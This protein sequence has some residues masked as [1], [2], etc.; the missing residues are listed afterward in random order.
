MGRDARIALDWADGHYEF[1]LAWGQLIELQEQCDAGPFVV[2]NRLTS[3]QWRMQDIGHT[4][5]LGL[6]GGGLE[7]AKALKL[8]RDYVESRPPLENLML[9]RGILAAALMGA[10]DEP[11]GEAQGEAASGSTTS[12]TASSE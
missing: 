12:P 8:T 9:A 4:I 6:I 7:P 2:L 5:R 11:P 1:R 10:P 3:G